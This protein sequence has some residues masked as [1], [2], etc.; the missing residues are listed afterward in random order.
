MLGDIAKYIREVIGT[1]NSVSQCRGSIIYGLWGKWHVDMQNWVIHKQVHLVSTWTVLE[2]GE[3]VALIYQE[4][5]CF[6]KCVL[7]V[8]G[9]LFYVDCPVGGWGL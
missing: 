2:G 3:G 7:A 1:C 9:M 5:S 6:L 8:V 4:F